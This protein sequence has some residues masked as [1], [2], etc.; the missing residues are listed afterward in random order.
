MKTVILASNNKGKIEQFKEIYEDTQILLLE[1]IGYKEEIEET[2]ET[3]F[4][5]ALIK[6]KTISLYARRKGYAYPVIADDSGLE[7]EALNG[8]PGVYSAR[9]SGVHGNSK[10][11]RKLVLEKMKGINNRKAH[12]TAC[13]VKYYPNDEYIYAYGRT[14]G[15]ILCEER[16][17]YGFGYDSIFYSDDLKKSFGEATNEEKKIISHRGR[18][19]VELEKNDNKI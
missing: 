15:H 3:F 14:Y 4:E 2:G 8:E 1:D 18:A 17:M 9:Y 6:A 16:G 10:E 5:N 13:I 11:N 19:I 12:Y 7:I